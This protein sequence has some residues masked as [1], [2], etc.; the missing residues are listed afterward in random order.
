M[1]SSMKIFK[2]YSSKFLAALFGGEAK[3]FRENP[4]LE[5]G[6]EA[7]DDDYRASPSD[8]SNAKLTHGRNNRRPRSEL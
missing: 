6:E 7:Y 5:S 2:R 3:N 4:P 8:G 1:N